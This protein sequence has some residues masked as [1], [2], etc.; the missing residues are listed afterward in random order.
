[1]EQ[2]YKIGIRIEQGILSFQH[3][4]KDS[5]KLIKLVLKHLLWRGFLSQADLELCSVLVLSPTCLL[6]SIYSK[7]CG[8]IHL[9]V[10][11]STK[12]VVLN[13]KILLKFLVG[14]SLK[15]SS[16]IP[17]RIHLP[18]ATTILLNKLAT[19]PTMKSRDRRSLK[20]Y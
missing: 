13:Q 17:T 15:K 10:V 11:Q 6:L 8:E 2:T 12:C 9:I 7:M 19:V 3:R 20:T 18:R 4:A 14:K 16:K 1:M 5:S